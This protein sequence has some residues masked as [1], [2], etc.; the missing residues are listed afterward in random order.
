MF[1]DPR[2]IRY[3]RRS[4]RTRRKLKFEFKTP[5]RSGEDVAKLEH[6]HKAF[7]DKIVYDDF[8]FLVRYGER[9][10]VMGANGAGKSTLLKLIVGGASAD[11]GQV[12]V[13]A[14]VKIG[15]FAQHA[16]DLLE[17]DLTA[18]ETVF[19][20]FP[21][22]SQGQLRTLLGVFGFPGDD[23][24]KPSRSARSRPASAPVRFPTFCPTRAADVR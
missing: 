5:P 2:W 17:P 16:M 10:C 11:R 18:W 19:N 14:S 7:G 23:A 21:A 12:Q 1:A 22:A 13:G 24:D 4:P 3:V 15:Y 9:W 8:S 6:V 20:A